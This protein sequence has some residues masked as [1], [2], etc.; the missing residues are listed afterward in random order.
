MYAT[1]V[2]SQGMGYSGAGAMI[3]FWQKGTGAVAAWDPEIE[4]AWDADDPH[5]VQWS[6]NATFIDLLRLACRV[7]D[8]RPSLGY[9]YGRGDVE[10]QMAA[11]LPSWGVVIVSTTTPREPAPAPD[12]L[13]DGVIVGW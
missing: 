1:E 13:V 4:P 10:D 3:R 9:G 2:L 8:L 5:R 11:L 7:E 12:A 6:G